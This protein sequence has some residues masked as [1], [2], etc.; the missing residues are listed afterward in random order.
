MIELLFCYRAHMLAAGAFKP[1]KLSNMFVR[2]WT[3]ASLHWLAGTI[4]GIGGR[5]ITQLAFVADF[6]PLKV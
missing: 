2:I 4:Q 1:M 3:S 6:V 5:G